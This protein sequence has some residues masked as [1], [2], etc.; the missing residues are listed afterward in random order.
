MGYT[1]ALGPSTSNQRGV[2]SLL[3]EAGLS[4]YEGGLGLWPY[5]SVLLSRTGQ[6][7]SEPSPECSLY[8]TSGFDKIE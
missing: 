5:S 2:I 4:L 8:C 6:A 3:V 7:Y 1:N